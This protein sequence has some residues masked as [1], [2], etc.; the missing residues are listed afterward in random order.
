MEQRLIACAACHGKQGEGGRRGEIYPRLAGKPAGY[1]YNQLSNFRAGRRKY[2]VMNYMVGYLSDAYLQEIAEYYAKLKP[3]YPP[4]ASGASRA[5]LARGERLVTRGDRSRKLPACTACHGRALTGM[6]PAIPALVG[7]SPDYIGEQMGAWRV[8]RRLAKEPDCMARIAAQLA[9]E[10]IS[11][12]AA[13]LAA[14]PASANAPP[15]LSASAKL[16]MR[17]GSVTQQPVA[18]LAQRV[19][20]RP[21][22]VVRGEYLALAGDCGGCHSARGGEPYAGGAPLVTP[23]GTLYAPNITPDAETGIGRWTPEDFW[24]AM[25]EGR[26]KDGTLL[27]PAFPYTN[28]TKVT[29]ADTD[30]LFAYLRSLKP[31]RKPNRNHEIRFPYNQRKLL[32]AWRALYFK[33]GA[34]RDDPAQSKEWNRGAY[35]VEGLGHCNACHSTRNMLGAVSNADETAGGLIP[36]QNWYAPSLNSNRETGL[37]DWAVGEVADLLKTGVSARG[38]VFGPMSTVVHDSLQHLSVADIT[39]IATYL[40][41]Q[42][43]REEP[44]EPTQIRVTEQQAEALVAEGTKLYDDRCVDCHQHHGE[45]VP[46]TYPP[47]QNNESIVMRYPINAIRVVVNG[48]FPPSTQ[49]NPRP[50]GMPPFGQDFSD[51]E[52]AAV[53]SYIRQ[54]WGNHAPAVS[55]AEISSARGIPVD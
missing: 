35:L 22:P 39:A 43:Q 3:A 15:K 1:L 29:R 51:R 26:S 34:Y 41:S 52:I 19:V 28:Y 20:H 6:E 55:S 45:G 48:G 54:A 21:D 23:F 37:G 27:Y 42:A 46:G 24:R 50:Y 13:W 33:A 25:H 53:V 14:Q 17:C 16:P 7:L 2:A 36:I 30:D 49:D 18:P 8:D 4:P 40:K 44:P 38:A 32:I 47:L 12:I 5:A 11:A 9:P 10:D 31:V